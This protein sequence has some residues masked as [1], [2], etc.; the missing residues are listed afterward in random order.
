MTAPAFKGTS[1]RIALVVHPER[2]QARELALVARRWWE[3]RG[4]TVL[5]EQSADEL[6]ASIDELD[7]IDLAVSLGGDGTM[8]RTVQ[9]G[10]QLGAIVLGV[11]LGSLG[12]LTQVEPSGMLKAFERLNVGDYEIE[13]RMI[14]D[15]TVTHGNQITTLT[16]LNEAVVEKI[17]P[18]HTI[19]VQSHIGGRPFLSYAADG[20]LVATPT[21]STA[22]N[23]SLRGPIVSPRMRCLILTPISPHMLFDRSVVLDPVESV[24]LEVLSDRPAALAVDGSRVIDLQ[25]GDSMLLGAGVNP[26]HIVSLG[27]SDFYGVL[28]AKFGLTDR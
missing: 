21:G 10:V 13:E 6:S 8:L 7:K 19:R 12:Y 26:A 28:R 15:V 11:N 20:I 2:E 4:H 27:A 16:G 9:I 24:V 25:P 22:Y 14:L 3:D 23:L 1:S 5:H 17:S 18:G